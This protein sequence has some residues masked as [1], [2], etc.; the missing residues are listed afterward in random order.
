M[1]T[2]QEQITEAIKSYYAQELKSNQDLK[3][4]ACCATESLPVYIREVLK[5]IHPEVTSRFYGCG[6]PIPNAIENKVVLDLGCGTGRDSFIFSKLVGENGHVIGI[7]MTP[8]QIAIAIKYADYH[9]NKFGYRCSNTTFHEGY[10]EDL[11]TINIEDN[12]IDLVTSN[13]VLNLC[14]DKQ[15]AFKEIFRVLKPGGELYFSDVFCSR[16]IP[17]NLQRDPI[18][19]GECLGGA[20]YIE[21]FRRLLAKLGCY[22]YRVVSNVRIQIN[23]EDIE[24]KVGDIEFF[25]ITM[26]AFNIE[27]EDRCENYGQVAWY[28]GGIEETPNQFMLD[29]HHIFE[30][31]RPM[32]V[33]SNTARMLSQSRFSRFFKVQGKETKHFG[34][35]ECGSSLSSDSQTAPSPCC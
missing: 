34:L 11:S 13:C 15:K 1:P 24:S 35:F 27:L 22:D 9:R 18:L 6:S 10:I 30:K 3:T 25:S 7:D 19:R 5:S 2:S 31:G 14:Y 29:D 20:L 8:A 26:R 28:L 33:C 23:N 16:R 4:N 12:S 21:D 32:L 17:E